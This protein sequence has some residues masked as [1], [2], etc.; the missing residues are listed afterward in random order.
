MGFSQADFQ[1]LQALLHK[2]RIRF[3]PSSYRPP[4]IQ[5][6]FLPQTEM[7]KRSPAKDRRK[8]PPDPGYDLYQLCLW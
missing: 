3:G 7:T 5:L 2:N 8:P 1:E 4:P 6:S